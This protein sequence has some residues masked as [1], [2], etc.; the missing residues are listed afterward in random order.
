VTA[1]PFRR[2]GA[3]VLLQVRLTPKG[4]RDAIDGVMVGDDGKPLLAVRVRAVPEDGAANA[5]LIAL[6][7]KILDV[8]RNAIS[9]A[10]G[11]KSRVKALEIAGDSA[12]IEAK[13]K[14]LCLPEL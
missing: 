5:A 2:G 7:A 14:A 3:G 4:G 13:L 6:L 8:R 10:S 9:L 1:L 11:G 12:A